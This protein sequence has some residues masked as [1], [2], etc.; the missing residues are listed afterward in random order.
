MQEKGGLR[1]GLLAAVWTLPLVYWSVQAYIVGRSFGKPIALADAFA[2]EILYCSLWVALTP[3]VLWLVRRFPMERGH[4]AGPALVHLGFAVALSFTHRLIWIFM[5]RPVVPKLRESTI[6]EQL[7][8]LMAYDYGVGIYWLTL[9]IDR[10]LIYRQQYREE[11]VRSA[12][13]EAQLSQAQLAALKMQ[14]HPHF[15]FNTLHAISALVQEDPEAAERMIA[16][17]SELLRLSLDNAGTQIA[18]LR[19]ELE[20][21]ERYLEIERIRFEDRLD[22]RFEI[23]PETLDA[24]VPNLILQPLV[25]NAIRHG[26]ANISGAGRIAIRSRQENGRLVL[27]VADNGIG[28]AD[29]VEVRQGMGLGITRARLEGLYGAGQRLELQPAEGGGLRV[30]LDLPLRKTAVLAKD[31]ELYAV[32]R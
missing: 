16:R 17:L 9:L 18:P 20:F 4:W 27:E 28:L 22:V 12:R 31:T 25:E 32:S 7:Q 30:T 15:L 23:E 3:L 5:A 13:L 21:L 10:A 1:L 29:G 2:G 19:K 11:E 8:M 14:L 6:T 26:L 24:V